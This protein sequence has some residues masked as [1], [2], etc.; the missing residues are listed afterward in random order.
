MIAN[1]LRVCVKWI[2]LV[3]VRNRYVGMRAGKSLRSRWVAIGQDYPGLFLYVIAYT[4][5]TLEKQVL[6]LYLCLEDA[7]AAKT[8]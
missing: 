7:K 1:A 3:V 8:S 5:V 2:E 6:S 4:V